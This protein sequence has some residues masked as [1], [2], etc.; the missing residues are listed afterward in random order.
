MNILQIVGYKNAGKTTTA[1][2]AIAHLNRLGYTVGAIKH[3]AHDF[4][5]D[6]PGTDSWR[7]REAGAA[8]TAIT[9]PSCTAW[10]MER[11]SELDEL[12]AVM[13]DNGVEAAIVEGFK[14]APYPKLVLL[15]DEA[16]IEL[17]SLTSI[18]A[19]AV[20]EPNERLRV[21][22]AKLDTPYFVI[23]DHQFAS[24]LAFIAASIHR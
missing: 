7:H 3:D 16:D 20:R 18:V 17:L 24:L 13:R 10:T 11:P 5:P 8:M 22:A 4:E 2:A 15:R 9:S 21:E 6:V 12:L 23:G 19:V 14:T 1:T